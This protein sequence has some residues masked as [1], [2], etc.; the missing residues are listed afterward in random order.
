M[1]NLK[2]FRIPFNNVL[3][4]PDE[5]YETYQLS[6]R[7]TGIIVTNYMADEKGN[8]VSIHTQNIAISGTVYAVPEKLVYNA[9]KMRKLQESHTLPMNWSVQREVDRLREASVQFEVD[10]EIEK[11][12]KVYFEYLAHE[13]CSK[14]GRWVETSEGMML[15]MKYDLLIMADRN[16]GIYPL[17]GNIIVENEKIEAPDTFGDIQ[18]KV[19]ENGLFIPQM[20]QLEHKYR[21]RA[22]AKVLYAGSAVREYMDFR[23]KYDAECEVGDRILY[24]PRFAKEIEYST[25]RV[26]DRKLLRIQRKDIYGIFEDNM[27]I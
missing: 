8:K 20:Y 19:S 24:D 1:I 3:V 9:P 27:V 12:D 15:L 10:I 4:K 26:F 22:I 5:D 14:D 18:G 13:L 6:G 25:H 2:T 11:G 23:G 16:G 17:N 21:N 7:E